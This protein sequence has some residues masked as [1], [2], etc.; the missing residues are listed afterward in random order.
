M[1][2]RQYLPTRLYSQLAVFSHKTVL[3]T[4]SI[5]PPD[6]NHILQYSPTRLY[7]QL[8]VFSHQTVLTNCSILPPDCTHPD[9]PVLNPDC[10]MEYTSL[11]EALMHTLQAHSSQNTA[12]IKALHLII[13]VVQSLSRTERNRYQTDTIEAQ[14]TAP[15]SERPVC[16]PPGE[17]TRSI[18]ALS[19]QSGT[20]ND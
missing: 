8:A 4:C 7:L 5:L 10:T 13:S 16:V 12:Y 9:G 20:R 14:R 19:P 11:T 6:C 17:R 1:V 3:I 15:F 18:E 2:Q